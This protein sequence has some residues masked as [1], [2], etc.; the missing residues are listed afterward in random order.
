MVY[1]KGLL[2]SNVLYFILQTAFESLIQDNNEL[3]AK[4]VFCAGNDTRIYPKYSDIRT[5]LPY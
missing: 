4:Q 5:F 1:G 2:F 3:I